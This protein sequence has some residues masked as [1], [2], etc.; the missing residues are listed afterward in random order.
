MRELRERNNQ[1]SRP[2]ISR[3]STACPSTA[4]SRGRSVSQ[5]PIYLSDDDELMVAWRKNRLAELKASSS[6]TRRQS[7][8]KRH[9]GRVEH[10]DAMGYL[11]AIEKVSKDTVVVVAVYSERV[12]YSETHI[13]RG[14]ILTHILVTRELLC[15]GLPQHRSQ[16]IPNDSVHPDAPH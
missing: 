9:F 1:Y 2:S 8:S 16:E 15:T 3:P 13:I 10:V 6:T 12:R 7:P 14:S 4:H 11:D 5:V